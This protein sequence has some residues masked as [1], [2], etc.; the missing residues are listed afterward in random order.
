M[1]EDGSFQSFSKN[2]SIMTNISSIID[3]I[4]K[5]DLCYSHYKNKL[6]EGK[7]RRREINYER[8][9]KIN[10]KNNIICLFDLLD[11]L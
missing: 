9:K 8:L 5:N 2:N 3:G 6:T 7:N 10:N 1:N 4:G 11:K